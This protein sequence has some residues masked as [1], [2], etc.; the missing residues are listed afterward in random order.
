MKLSDVQA[1]PLGARGLGGSPA[2]AD[3]EPLGM[4]NYIVTY[5]PL[6]ATKLGRMVA[7]RTGIPPYVDASCRREPDLEQRYPSV[8]SLCRGRWFVPRLEKGDRIV[9]LTVC[10]NYPGED[11]RH[12]RLTAILKVKRILDNHAEAALWYRARGLPIPTNCMIPGNRPLPLKLTG[13]SGVS[14]HA[15][16]AVYRTRADETGAF[17]VCMPLFR[18]LRVPPVVRR[19]DLERIFGEIPAT[20]TPRGHDLHRFRRLCHIAGVAI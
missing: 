15:W 16:D 6:A 10:G 17:A 1:A 20:R 8:T 3:C 7:E 5:R 14:L 13:E 2:R 19:R 11:F 18:E 9:Y 12:W 4:A